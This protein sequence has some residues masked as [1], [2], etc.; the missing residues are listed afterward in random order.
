MADLEVLMRTPVL[1]TERLVLRAPRA[2]DAPAWTAFIGSER[3]RFVGGPVDAGR[4]WRSFAGLVGHWVLRGYG[5]FVFHLRDDPAPLGMVGPWHPGDWPER[6]IGWSAWTEAAEGRGFV[7]EAARA[8]LSHVFRD[9]GWTTAVS[10]VD[11]ENARSI[12]LAERLGARRD[13]A[14]ERPDPG[15]LVFRHP[16]PA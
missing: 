7:A 10:Y 3:S 16:R 15:G 4:G 12:A 5:S 8:V 11:P 13:G 1:A 2:S 6:E 9:L 14:A